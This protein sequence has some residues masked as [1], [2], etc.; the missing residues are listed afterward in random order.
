MLF[1]Q[2]FRLIL[3]KFENIVENDANQDL[4]D[5]N[6]KICTAEEI[7]NRKVYRAKTYIPKS[8]LNEDQKQGNFEWGNWINW[9]I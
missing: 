5:E 2:I 6:D 8:S 9:I 3:W 7:E 4:V 1:S